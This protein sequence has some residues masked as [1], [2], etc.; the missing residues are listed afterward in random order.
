MTACH[1]DVVKNEVVRTW[2]MGNICVG[3]KTVPC[4]RVEPQVPGHDAEPETGRT[5]YCLPWED[6]ERAIAKAREPCCFCWCCFCTCACKHSVVERSRTHPAE[7]VNS[8]A[9]DANLNIGKDRVTAEKLR[10]WMF[11][12]E[13]LL[14]DEVG[15]ILF[16]AFLQQEYSEENL[17]FWIEVE[18]M[19]A[20]PDCATRYITIRKIYRDYIQPRAL[21]EVNVEAWIRKGI[22]EKLEQPP[23]DIF[24]PA[25]TQVYLLMYRQSW[26]RFVASKYYQNLMSQVKV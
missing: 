22:E 9:L 18:R 15:K 17:K 10:R 16:E 1:G 21:N 6:K 7:E 12:F 8:T 5:A 25:Q 26:P 14:R 20:A 2:Q 13:A 23:P 24:D 11:D 3:R 4:F 19:K